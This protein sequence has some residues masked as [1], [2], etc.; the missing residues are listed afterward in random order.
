MEATYYVMS[1]TVEV[2]DLDNRSRHGLV[3]GSMVL[4]DPGTRYRLAAGP[5][6]CEMVGGPCPADPGMYSELDRD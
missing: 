1:G 4:V 5:N 6:G 3:A 2:D